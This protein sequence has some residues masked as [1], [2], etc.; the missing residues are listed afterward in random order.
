[1]NPD[2]RQARLL[3]VDAFA[4]ALP[5]IRLDA[6]ESARIRNGQRLTSSLAGGF[7]R[8]YDGS[9]N[10]LGV[11]EAGGEGL[12]AVRLTSTAVLPEAADT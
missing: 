8:L 2:D 12:A 11:G 6:A 1:L 7:Y 3:P 9:G 5:E 4:L 10:F